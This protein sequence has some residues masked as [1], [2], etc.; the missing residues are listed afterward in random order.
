MSDELSSVEMKSLHVE[1][2][3]ARTVLSMFAQDANG[4]NDPALGLSK[5]VMGL[6]SPSSPGTSGTSD[7]AGASSS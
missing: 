6:I 1:L 2:L 5:F 4:G 3:P 7:G